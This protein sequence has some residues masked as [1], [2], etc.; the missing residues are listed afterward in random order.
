[1]NGTQSGGNFKKSRILFSPGISFPV[2]CRV[3][4]GYNLVLSLVLGRGTDS[5][6]GPALRF[7]RMPVILRLLFPIMPDQICDIC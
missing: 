2:S 6:T 7:G 4:D 1:M 5:V 3:D